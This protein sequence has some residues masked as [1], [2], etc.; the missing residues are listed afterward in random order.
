ML[1]HSHTAVTG[2]GLVA[3]SESE[4]SLIKLYNIT[5]T[6][7]SVLSECIIFTLDSSKTGSALIVVPLIVY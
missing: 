7:S 4:S 5:D 2:D 1:D 3:D 6:E